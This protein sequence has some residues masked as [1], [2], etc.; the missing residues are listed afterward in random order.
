MQ[1]ATVVSDA[2]L[3][4][5]ALAALW[6]ARP[7]GLAMAGFALLALAAAVGSLRY[8][9]APQLLP[10]HQGLAFLAGT[11]GLPLVLL[12]YAGAGWR[13]AAPAIGALLLLSAAAWMQPPTR[14]VVGLATLLG[15]ALMLW[16]DR[17]DALLAAGIALGIAASLAAGAWAPQ[18]RWQDID[19]MHY[20]LALAQLAF[21]V[22]LWRRERMDI[23]TSAP[24]QARL[25][26]ETC[27]PSSAP[28]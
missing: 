8:G 5:A 26:G 24:T 11:L 16:R 15:W 6:L 7:R 19:A 12:G 22:A 17:R 4:A 21:G 1:A 20:A 9:P 27:Q 2:V 3:C 18:G 13:T 25:P 10:L 28:P 14:L 23:K